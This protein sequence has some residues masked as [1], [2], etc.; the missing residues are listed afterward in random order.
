MLTNE[1]PIQA[2]AS[3]FWSGQHLHLPPIQSLLAPGSAVACDRVLLSLSLHSG[4]GG[5]A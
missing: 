4:G 1:T 3:L 5:G 2:A